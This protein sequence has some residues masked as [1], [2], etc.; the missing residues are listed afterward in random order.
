MS[1]PLVSVNFSD[2]KYNLYE[3]LG[4]DNKTTDVKIKKS[5]RKLVIELHPDKNPDSNDEIYQHVIIANQ[6]LSNPATRKDYDNYLLGL[7]SKDSFIDL[8]SGFETNLKDVEKYFPVKDN[9]KNTFKN[10]ID[11]LNK[12]HGFNENNYSDSVMVQYEQ[13]KKMRNNQISIPQEKISDNKDFNSKFENKVSTGVF[14]DQIIVSE[15]TG[16]LGTYQPHDQL[17]EIS[18]YSRLYSEDSVSTGSYTSLDM[19]FKIQKIN[20]TVPEKSVEERLK[21][22]KNQTNTYNNRKPG[23]F[24]NKKF[25]DWSN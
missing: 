15:N 5:F 19:A 17:V 16:S 11:E 12:K 10:K 25:D 2:L 7:N 8:K 21:E 4:L 14:N 23:D 3:V 13:I 20:A 9:A 22:Y 18:D 6:V 24:S 1:K